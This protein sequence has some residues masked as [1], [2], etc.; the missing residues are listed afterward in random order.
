[1]QRQC[2]DK[3][4]SDSHSCPF[5]VYVQPFGESN[6][7]TFSTSFGCTVW[8]SV[9]A[10]FFPNRCLWWQHLKPS[11]LMVDGIALESSRATITSICMVPI[12]GQ[13]QMPA[14]CTLIYQMLKAET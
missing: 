8:S 12:R 14:T 3:P 13:C 2:E 1:G 4:I 11:W 7:W 9:E 10:P 5:Q 6:L